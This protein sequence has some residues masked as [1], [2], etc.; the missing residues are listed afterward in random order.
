MPTRSSRCRRRYGYVVSLGAD[1]S[2][3]HVM[4][5]GVDTHLF[6]PGHRDSRVRHRW[7]W[8]D[9]EGPVLGFVGGL[10]PWHGVEILPELFDRLAPYHRGLCLV[11]VGDGPLRSR[12]E[13]RARGI[14]RQVVFTGTVAQ[15]EVAPMIR[16]FDMALAPYPKLDHPFY[17]SPLK[18]FEYMACGVPVVASKIGQIAEVVEDGVT[19]MLYPAGDLNGLV[20]ACRRLIADPDLRSRIGQ[21]AT[22]EVQRC[23]TWDHNSA[24]IT[25]LARS[26]IAARPAIL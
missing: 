10:R 24:A 7:G 9:G 21:A 1:P 11:I 6:K 16:E 4:T 26:F 13:E 12:L 19:G 18:L 2:R 3:V 22:Q 15:E 5:N 17:F 23:Y 8:T 25:E 14:A 20:D